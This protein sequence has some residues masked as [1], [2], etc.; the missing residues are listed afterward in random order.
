MLAV[1]DVCWE[2]AYMSLYE[3]G[4]IASSGYCRVYRLWE[5]HTELKYM[6]ISLGSNEFWFCY[7]LVGR[8]EGNEEFTRH[9]F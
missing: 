9:H 1:V 6:K 4:D 5:G 3:V 7:L 8:C 2:C